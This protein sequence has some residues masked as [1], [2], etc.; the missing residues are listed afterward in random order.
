MMNSNIQDS[1]FQGS[2]IGATLTA[3]GIKNALI[4]FHGVAGCNIE[5]IH[6][7]SDQIPGGHYVPI[8][9]T[10]INS[11]DCLYGGYDKLITTLKDTL[12]QSIK[13][14][15]PPEIIF[16]FISDATSIIGDDI[17]RAASEIEN[18]TGIKTIAF[19][20]PAFSGGNAH[21]CDNLAVK[22]LEKLNLSFDNEKKGLN[23]LFPYLMGSKNWIND[24]EEMKRLLN[25]SEIPVNNIFAR[26]MDLQNLDKFYNSEINYNPSYE[27]INELSKYSEKHNILEFKKVL[28]LPIGIANTEEWLLYFANEYGNIEQAKKILKQDSDFINSQLR[29]NYNFSWISTLMY[30][31]YCSVIGHAM[32]S[33]SLARCLYWDF[34]IIPKVIA[35]IGETTQSID[36]AM[37]ILKPMLENIETEVLVNPT[38]YEYGKKMN[39]AQVDFSVGA[40]QDKPLSLSYKIPHISLGGFYFYNQFN[41]IPYPNF[42]IR[43]VLGLLTELSK[44][45]EDAFYMKDMISEYAYKNREEKSEGS[46]SKRGK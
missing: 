7:R 1:M 20:C 35:L 38:Y 22:I 6:F 16:I 26:N 9:P 14:N 24:I 44:V 29:Y 42:G 40:V 25:G 17:T 33:A 11:T 36:S 12:S 39:N 43:G 41:F 8:V 34:G 46:C 15:K 23:I 32:F 5:A 18:E 27:E 13:R 3:S 19:D 4:I 2:F 10:G 30:G 37:E 45:M 28:P 21:G 31:K